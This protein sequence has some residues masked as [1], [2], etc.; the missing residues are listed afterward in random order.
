MDVVDQNDDHRPERRRYHERNRPRRHQQEAYRER[1]AVD[2]EV[3][4][5]MHEILQE[6]RR[7]GHEYEQRHV[8]LVEAEGSPEQF[9]EKAERD[10]PDAAGKREYQP[11]RHFREKQRNDRADQPALGKAEL[12]IDQKLNVV[13]L[14]PPRDLLANTP[15]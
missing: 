12:I 1:T 15:T 9:N 3:P 8:R 6:E 2:I 14:S 10:Q 5:R 7:A 11:H 4:K 13:N